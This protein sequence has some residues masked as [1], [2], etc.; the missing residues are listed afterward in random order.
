MADLDCI[1]PNL[2]ESELNLPGRCV[3]SILRNKTQISW[4]SVRVKELRVSVP[5]ARLR[6]PKVSVIGDIEHL[7]PELNAERFRDPP[8]G[9]VLQDREIPVEEMRPEDAIAADVTQKIGAISL[10]SRAGG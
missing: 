8:D 5:A 2:L 7:R 3:C 9:E 1:L 4:R 10:P 6:W